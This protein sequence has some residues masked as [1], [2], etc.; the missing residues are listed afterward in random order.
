MPQKSKVPKEKPPQEV[1]IVTHAPRQPQSRYT[2]CNAGWT[3]VKANSMLLS[4]IPAML[5]QQMD[6]QLVVLGSA[7]QAAPGGTEAQKLAPKAASASVG[8]LWA[9]IATFVQGAL[10]TVP[11]ADIPPILASIFMYASKAGTRTPK[12][13]LAASHG[14]TSGSVKLVA[15]AIA[16]ALSY[17]WEWS[18]DQTSWST[19]RTGEAN[20]TLSGLTPGKVYYFRVRS[21]LRGNTMT[22]YTQ[23]VSIMAI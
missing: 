16:G 19:S 12:A 14:D 21:F 3:A 10:R 2:Q 17:E 9:Q 7:L 20:T 15:L 1:K 11:H 13:P 6:A 23:T 8:M 22:D 18:L 4:A 5:A